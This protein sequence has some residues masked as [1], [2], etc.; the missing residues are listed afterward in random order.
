VYRMKT[1][2]KSRAASALGLKGRRPETRDS[3]SG[4]EV[5]LDINS[6]EF[7]KLFAERAGG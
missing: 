3:A 4:R 7:D 1:Q 6:P 2:G 5:L